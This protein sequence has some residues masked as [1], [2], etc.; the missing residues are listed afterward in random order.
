M[1]RPIVIAA[2]IA[3]GL[4]AGY[5]LRDALE[6]EPDRVSRAISLFE[7]YCVPF[8]DSREIIIN[9]NMER[10]S[11]SG[12]LQTWAEP[13]SHLM[14]EI[15]KNS[16]VISDQLDYLAPHEQAKLEIA[17][18]NAVNRSFPELVDEAADLSES[19]EVFEMWMQFE[20]Q[21]PR[22]WGVVFGRFEAEGPSAATS[23]TTYAH[24][25]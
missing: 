24:N 25:E 4:P 2:V 7:T 16:C 22:R 3:L 14:L 12:A 5:F 8:A 20:K 9:G 17:I 1:Y 18:R 11:G 19:W 10:I 23:I 15:N 13:K 6:P 21:D